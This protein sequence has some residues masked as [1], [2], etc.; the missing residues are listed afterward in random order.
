MLE[1]EFSFGDISKAKA[2][3]SIVGQ[4]ELTATLCV[5]I[6]GSAVTVFKFNKGAVQFENRKRTNERESVAKSK[7][8][9]VRAR[10]CTCGK[11]NK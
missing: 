9:Q 11:A 1:I 2:F 5:T 10:E 4:N 6:S 3:K 7:C 8:D